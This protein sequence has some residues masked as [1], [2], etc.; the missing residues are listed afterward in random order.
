MR[1][2]RR[3]T[4]RSVHDLDVLAFG[5]FILL[6]QLAQLLLHLL[7]FPRAIV[8]ILGIGGDGQRLRE[9]LIIDREHDA[10]ETG[11]HEAAATTASEAAAAS[12][13]STTAPAASCARTAAAAA[14]TTR[15]TAGSAPASSA[16]CP[17]L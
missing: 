2:E 16:S 9:G 13:S 6:V 15:S 8:G 5:P 1:I 3:A 11:R 7:G 10:V 14:T 17:A 12:T 4:P